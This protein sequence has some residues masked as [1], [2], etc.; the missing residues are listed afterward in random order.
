M[1]DAG[2]GP[3]NRI[4]AIHKAPAGGPEVLVRD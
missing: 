1:K 4:H 3:P 2:V